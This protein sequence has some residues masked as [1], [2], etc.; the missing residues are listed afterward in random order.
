M[1]VSII[2]FHIFTFVSMNTRLVNLQMECAR[3]Q[4]RCVCEKSTKGSTTVNCLLN[5]RMTYFRNK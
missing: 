5:I 3:L 4:E 2:L 1:V